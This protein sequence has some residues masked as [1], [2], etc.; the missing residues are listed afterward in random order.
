VSPSTAALSHI[1]LASAGMS[2]SSCDQEKT[3]DILDEAAWAQIFRFISCMRS[4]T[5]RILVLLMVAWTGLT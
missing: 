2:R 4:G 3:K 5:V 1:Q